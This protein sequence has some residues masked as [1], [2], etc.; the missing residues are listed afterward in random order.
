M[1]NRPVHRISCHLYTDSVVVLDRF[2]EIM[3]MSRASL[4]RDLLDQSMPHLEAMADRLAALE[5]GPDLPAI[6]RAERIAEALDAS[7]RK[8]VSL[9]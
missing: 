9:L 6:A 8:G 7:I 1:S 3:G 5:A 2:A 4:M